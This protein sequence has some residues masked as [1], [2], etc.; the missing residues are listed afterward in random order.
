MRRDIPSELTR[1]T[2]RAAMWREALRTVAARDMRPVI[3]QGV[4]VGWQGDVRRDRRKQA[5]ALAKKW[6]L[7]RPNRSANAAKQKAISTAVGSAKSK[8]Q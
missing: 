6:W 7:A 3:S 8:E 1:Q 2:A 4:Q 5:R